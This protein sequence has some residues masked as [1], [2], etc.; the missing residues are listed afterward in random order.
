MDPRHLELWY[1]VH[2]AQKVALKTA[3]RGVRAREVD[4]AAREIIK[5][6]M[7]EFRIKMRER[8]FGWSKS[9]QQQQDHHAA[10][11]E[12]DE[13]DVNDYFTHRL[14]HG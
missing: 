7:R 9:E 2:A 10:D 8:R 6:G 4:K 3:R 13:F 5:A 11:K 14:G 1:V 12:R